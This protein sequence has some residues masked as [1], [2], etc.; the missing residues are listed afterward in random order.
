MKGLLSDFAVLTY[1]CAGLGIT[2]RGRQA[3]RAEAPVLVVSPHSSFLDAVII[4]LTGLSSPLVRNADRNL[5]KLIDY[6][7]PIYVCREDPHSR[8]STIREIIQ[9]AN[10]TEDWPQIL[11]FPEGTCTNRTSLIQ[12]K[13][14]AFYP[15]VPIQ[16]VLMRYPNEVDTVTW[17]WEGPSA[18]QLLWRTLTK[19]HTF[20]EIEFLPVYYPSEAEK[21]D[22]KLYA[23]NVRDLMAQAL[24][25]PI[26]DYTF[27]DCK[28]MTYVK[29]I[30][31]PY[32]SA[33]A[34]IEKLRR[35]AG[36]A[37]EIETQ[38][39]WDTPELTDDNR[40][41]TLAQFTKTFCLIENHE[42]TA[43][44]FEIFVKPGR[45]NMIDLKEYLLMTLF[46]NSLN[47]PKLDFVT[48]LFNLYG[49]YGAVTRTKLYDALKYV[50]KISPEEVDVLFV[51][52]D[53]NCNGE[54]GMAAS[55]DFQRSTQSINPDA[56]IR[57]DEY[58]NPFVLKLELDDPWT[59]LR[60]YLMTI[61]VLP[62]RAVLMCLC[63]VVAWLFASI[64]LY[65]L[66]EKERR[67]IPISGWRREMRELTAL[68]MRLLY[69]F[70]SF[71][72]IKVYGE[73][74]SPR[75]APFVVVGP[76]YSLFDSIVVAFCG[77]STVVAKSKA[78]DLP[79]I[80]KIIDITQPIYVCREDPNSR[81]MTRHLLVERVISKDDW[82]QILV[83]PEGTCSNGKAIVQ[84]KPG[85]FGPG[86]PVQPVAIRYPNAV[87]TV[88][89]TWEGPGVP[90]LLWRTLTTLHTRFEIHFLPV[91]YPNE[92]ERNDAK[93]YA[94]N[95]RNY[96]ASALGIPGTEH[97]LN[98]C[99]LM[100]YMITIGMPY[101]AWSHDI[102]KMR[103]WLGL[104]DG[105]VEQ[106]LIEQYA[107][108]T[109]ENSLLSL[110]EFARRLGVLKEDHSTRILF[111][112][113]HEDHDTSGLIDFREY[114]LLAVFLSSLGKPKFDLLK[115][116]FK[117]YSGAQG[118]LV[119][120]E[121]LHQ[122]LKHLSTVTP[123]QCDQLFVKADSAGRGLVSFD[124]FE[125]SIKC[126]PVLLDLQE[127]N[128]PKPYA[129][130]QQAQ[131]N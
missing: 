27:D 59:K 111:K 95:V 1:T 127:L 94:L 10:S 101:F 14:G 124:Q 130:P 49:K 25:I 83:F 4:Y 123:A 7:Q 42:A 60:T 106:Q 19:F 5:G 16:P 43:A 29:N 89:W 45:P 17:T 82:P 56:R 62:V 113:F 28:L 74:A 54:I 11:I 90:I 86:M 6:A 52:A 116:L 13:P 8:Q 46:L 107:P 98:D 53:T 61:F 96:I 41:V 114:L 2:I 102:S 32:A 18:I 125:A 31:L 85:A 30:N 50:V 69:F 105:T 64:G 47:K 57:E 110:D 109:N 117:L 40:Y 71:H 129:A 108:F 48:N 100:N 67:S 39:T 84:F 58:V 24:N 65:G 93:L 118:G 77:P 126:H 121:G 112:I 3:R 122:A 72:Y 33:I 51:E 76:H 73:C 26:S 15:G 115:L 21:A 12:F 37:P 91:Y 81:H 23:R 35:L 9:R 88:S 36:S 97:G 99:K 44:L 104:A 38:V 78:A 63:L 92:Q 34:D 80:G 70:G 68:A 79:L 75:E 131:P 120:R 22:P 103:K 87:N 119:S 66:S 20:C 128:E 55:M